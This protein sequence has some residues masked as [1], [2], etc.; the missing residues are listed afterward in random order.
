MVGLVMAYLY[1]RI[2][3]FSACVLSCQRDLPSQFGRRCFMESGIVVEWRSGFPIKSGM[4]V[5]GVG[6]SGSERLANRDRG[7]HKGCP[8]G[9]ARWF[10]LFAFAVAAV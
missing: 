7:N 3:N 5:E 10:R 8:Y 4:G 1:Y 9:R 2:D 6:H